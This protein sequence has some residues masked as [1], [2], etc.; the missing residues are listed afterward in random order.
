MDE[1]LLQKS[2]RIVTTLVL[3]ILLQC[4]KGNLPLPLCTHVHKCHFNKEFQLSL[5]VLII[6]FQNQYLKLEGLGKS[7]GNYCYSSR[8]SWRTRDHRSYKIILKLK[9][10]TSYWRNWKFIIT[11]RPNSCPLM[12]LKMYPANSPLF[13]QFKEIIK[14]YDD[15]HALIN[16][17]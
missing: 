17:G 8:S 7:W 9:I 14:S 11:C 6:L 10:V 4:C 3:S 13:K 1:L 2:S 16:C 12:L 5:Q 15:I